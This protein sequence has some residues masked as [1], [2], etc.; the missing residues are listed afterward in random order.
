MMTP[1]AASGTQLSPRAGVVLGGVFVAMGLL[2]IC[3]AAG[4]F[5]RPETPVEAPRW[6][7]VCAGLMFALVG[8]ACIVGFGVAGGAAPDGDLPPDTPF[9]VRLTQYL[10]GLAIVILLAAIFSWVAFGPGPRQFAMVIPFLG[11]SVASETVGR[12]AFGFGAALICTF[13]VAF[14]VVGLRR[15]RK[16]K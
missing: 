3:I 9:G 2:V 14:G 10:L 5:A 11:R 1:P 16:G 8:V 13:L 4:L 7:G 15:L 6:V 12:V